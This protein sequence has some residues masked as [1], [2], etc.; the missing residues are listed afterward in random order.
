VADD[1][2]Q[3]HVQRI[4]LNGFEDDVVDHVTQLDVLRIYLSGFVYIVRLVECLSVPTD[5]AS[6]TDRQRPIS[7]W[8]W[9]LAWHSAR[10]EA[11]PTMRIW[12]VAHVT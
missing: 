5:R 2:A 7:P 4:H 1:L 9:L 11:V 8:T 10:P 6:G 3:S 12:S